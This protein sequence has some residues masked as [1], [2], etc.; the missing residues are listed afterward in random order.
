MPELRQASRFFGT[1]QRT[2]D[3]R[4][5]LV[6]RLGDRPGPAA[7]SSSESEDDALGGAAKPSRCA[8]CG[9][10]TLGQ[11]TSGWWMYE[12]IHWFSMGFHDG[13]G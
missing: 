13:D 6:S 10:L 4:R 5:L 3:R 11:K 7:G 9:H 2:V 1:T 12:I 8:K